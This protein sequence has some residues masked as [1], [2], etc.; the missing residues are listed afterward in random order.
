MDPGPI[1][2]RYMDCEVEVIYL[3]DSNV[4]RDKGTL[5]ECDG[6]FVVLQKPANEI[7]LIPLTAIRIIKVLSTP[8]E[9]VSTLLRP[10]EPLA[11]DVVRRISTQGT[12]RDDVS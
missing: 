11:G 7:F 2:S 6:T 12:G 3:T 1:I 10:A 4:Y 9:P 8:R 5:S